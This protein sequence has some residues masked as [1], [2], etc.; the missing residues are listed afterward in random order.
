MIDESFK[1]DLNSYIILTSCALCLTNI[2]GWKISNWSKS[3]KWR[4]DP[5][6][7]IIIF[8]LCLCK[9]CWAFYLTWQCWFI[10]IN[11]YPKA[12][13][14]TIK[15]I[16]NCA[17]IKKK[18]KIHSLAATVYDKRKVLLSL[19]F[20]EEL[21]CRCRCRCDVWTLDCTAKIRW[22]GFNSNMHDST[23]S[24]MNGYFWGFKMLLRFQWHVMKAPEVNPLL[25]A[26]TYLSI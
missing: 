9:L 12:S 2:T 22:T 14:S 6:R 4:S 20:F 21:V 25:C 17:P 5:L 13:E 15:L 26:L 19:I 10:T 16:T 23:H 18:L 7:L 11:H 24:Y 1:R 3:T 8:N